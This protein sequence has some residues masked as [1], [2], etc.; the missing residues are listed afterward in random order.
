[1]MRVIACVTSSHVYVSFHVHHCLV[2]FVHIQLARHVFASQH[3]TTYV[4][5]HSATSILQHLLRNIG[6]NTCW[7]MCC[8]S[9]TTHVA[10]HMLRYDAQHKFAST[11]DLHKQKVVVFV[12]TQHQNAAFQCSSLEFQHHLYLTK[13]ICSSN[14]FTKLKVQHFFMLLF[15]KKAA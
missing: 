12:F 15:L 9:C 7:R 1:M 10:Q 4:A 13:K 2:K 14:I 8:A 11:L 6:R 5:H 3:S